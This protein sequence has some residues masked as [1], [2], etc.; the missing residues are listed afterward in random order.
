MQR[1]E[2]KELGEREDSISRSLMMMWSVAL[3][4]SKP[5][6]VLSEKAIRALADLHSARENSRRIGTAFIIQRH[7]SVQKRQG[8]FHPGV[9]GPL[10]PQT[11]DA[12]TKAR[13]T[14]LKHVICLLKEKLFG[15]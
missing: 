13:L 3:T 9:S 4:G 15:A 12:D 11:N 1:S 5:C 7:G 10:P 2:M 6:Q 14:I 8:H